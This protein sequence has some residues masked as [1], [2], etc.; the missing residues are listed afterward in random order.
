MVL[1]NVK[2]IFDNNLLFYG[3]RTIMSNNFNLD[4]KGIKWYHFQMTNVEK[5]STQR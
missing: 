5:D 3:K 4:A 1:E 2:Y